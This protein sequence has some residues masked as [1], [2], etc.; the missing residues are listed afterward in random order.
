MRKALKRLLVSH[1]FHVDTYEHGGD[2]LA[3]LGANPV[4][5]LV[6]DLHMPEVNGFDVLT[7]FETR[8]IT[9]PVV[10]IT[11]HDGP[12]IEESTLALGAFAYLTNQWTSWR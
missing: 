4:A 10:V 12:G 1:G 8:R 7:E 2:F 3:A 9:A 6:L 11:G 5:C